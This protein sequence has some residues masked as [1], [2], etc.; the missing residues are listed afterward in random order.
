[1]IVQYSATAVKRIKKLPREKQVKL[2]Q[3]VHLL[4]RNPHAGKQLK[5]EFAPFRSLRMW[6]YR[7]MYQYFSDKKCIFI[8]TVEHRQG[9]YK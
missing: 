9:V 2:L 4:K 5:G 8:N 1:M 7:I 3:M 6:P